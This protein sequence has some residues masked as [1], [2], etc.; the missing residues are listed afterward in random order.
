MKML[1]PP[2]L[3]SMR[4]LPSCMLRSTSAPSIFS[5]HWAVASGFGLRRWTWSHV[6]LAI[7]V[8]PWLPAETL[9]PCVA[10]RQRLPLRDPERRPPRHLAALHARVQRLGLG[11]RADVGDHG[12]HLAT[13][14]EVE[15]FEN[16]AARDVAAAQNVL[17]LVE[18]VARRHVEGLAGAAQRDQ[19]PMAA[20]R[21]G[22]RLERARRRHVVDCHVDALALRE[23]EQRFGDIVG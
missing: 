16:L 4:G 17:L 15:R 18:Q 22:G 1:A 6:Y 2:S 8:A 21:V 14:D 13:R 12:P 19:P 20:E 5:N 9:R 10:P 3:R 7:L 23:L 11:K